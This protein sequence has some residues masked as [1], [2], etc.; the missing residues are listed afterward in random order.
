MLGEKLK[1]ARK[2]KGFSQD[3]VAEKLKVTRQTVSKWEN[4][5]TAPDVETLVKLS[6]LY[7]TSLD[8]LMRENGNQE[9]QIKEEREEGDNNHILLAVLVVLVVSCMIPALG[10]P[11]SVAVLVYCKGKSSQRY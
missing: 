5:R 11:V 2:A 9:C 1:N 6:D 10:L 8:L 3:E 7:E 4:G